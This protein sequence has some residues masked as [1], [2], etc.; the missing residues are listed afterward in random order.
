MK[1]ID[2]IP[3]WYRTGRQR[4]VGYRRQY[5]I[6]VCLFA[7]MAGWSFI[8]GMSVSR[9]RAEASQ[10]EQTFRAD[11]TINA[12]F[13]DIRKELAGLTDRQQC[14]ARVDPKVDFAA[15]LAEFSH[16]VAERVILKTLDIQ[17]ERYQNEKKSDRTSMIVLGADSKEKESVLPEADQRY[18]LKLTGIAA[19][20]SDVAG[21]ITALES[22]KYFCQILPGFSKTVQV[23][24]TAVTEFE[25]SCYLASYTL[26]K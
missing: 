2:F 23:K 18:R 6:I 8:T 5:T 19:D 13:D 26:N 12:R 11:E 7:L 3:E 14:L 16:L 10:R 24:N 20:A 25:V 1:D 4:K 21:L 9:S 17:S 22:S 15:V